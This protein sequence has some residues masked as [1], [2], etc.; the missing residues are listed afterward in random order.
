MHQIHDSKEN[1]LESIYALR[2]KTDIVRSV[3]IA[4]FLDVSKASVSIAMRK[5]RDENYIE[6]AQDGAITLLPAGEEIAEKT[7]N[8]HILIRALLVH[9]GVNKET[10][11]SDACKIEHAISSESYEALKKYAEKIGLRS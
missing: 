2:E 9:A 4:R 3:D 10:A 8:R 5:L 6:M 7:Y 11:N 1:Y